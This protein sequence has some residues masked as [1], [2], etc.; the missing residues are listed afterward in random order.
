MKPLVSVAV[1]TFNSQP[2][3]RQCIDSI[4]M[5]NVDFDYEIVVGDDCSGD[6]TPDIL[7]EYS[8]RFPGKFILLLNETNEGV[9][10]NNIKVLSRCRGR[11]IAMCEGDDYWYDR[12]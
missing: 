2:T 5:Q 7:L 6:S 1:L 4:L 8:D 9:S 12:N 10:K 11:Y 3:V